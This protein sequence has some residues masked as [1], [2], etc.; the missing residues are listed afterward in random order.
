[1]RSVHDLRQLWHYM[2]S[3]WLAYR[4]NYAARLRTGQMQRQLPATEWAAQ[5]LASFLSDQALAEPERYVDYRRNA[6]GPLSP[7]L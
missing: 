3:R 7:A 1:M 2:G 6:S 5:P 4:L